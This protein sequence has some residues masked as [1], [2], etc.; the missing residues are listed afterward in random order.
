MGRRLF[1]ANE[2]R[3]N[4]TTLIEH[5][6]QRYAD[7]GHDPRYAYVAADASFLYLADTTQEARAAFG[8]T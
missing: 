6:R 3:D 7:H 5:Y 8:P 4:Y 2:P 1:S